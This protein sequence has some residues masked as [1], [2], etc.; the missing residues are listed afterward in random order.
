VSNA[1]LSDLFHDSHRVMSQCQELMDFSPISIAL[2][3]LV[4]MMRGL[5]A[6]EGVEGTGSG[7][8]M[9]R[10]REAL[11]AWKTAWKS[12]HP[13]ITK[14]QYLALRSSWCSAEMYLS[15]PDFILKMVREV[16]MGDSVYKL[17]ANFIN[18]SDRNATAFDTEQFNNILNAC[19]AALFHI[20]AIAKFKSFDDCIFT[21]R[22]SVIPSV[23]ASIS[24]GGLCL[25]FSMRVIRIRHR[26]N[27]AA[28]IRV[29]SRFKRALSS[30]RWRP[31]PLSFI[32]EGFCVFLGNLIAQTQVW[33]MFLN[34]EYIEW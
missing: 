28:E 17:A 19:A 30:I 21:I 11:D 29:C 22:A 1:L 7:Y 23:I 31:K 26:S 4:S 8:L 6:A 5:V 9:K 15:A 12:F 25:W 24:L 14:A 13:G 34:S 3:E 2:F 10:S 16:S 33:G 18:E 27:P 32:D 20:E